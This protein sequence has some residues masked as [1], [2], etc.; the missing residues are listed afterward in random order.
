MTDRQQMIERQ[1]QAAPDD[2][3][4]ERAADDGEI[5]RQTADDGK[6]DSSR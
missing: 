2:G 5:D 1:T 4:R 3:E 6:T